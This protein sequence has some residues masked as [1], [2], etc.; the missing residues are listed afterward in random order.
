MRGSEGGARL[1]YGSGFAR[2]VNTRTHETQKK[3]DVEVEEAKEGIRLHEFF[4]VA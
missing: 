4:H 1:C 2:T 3:E